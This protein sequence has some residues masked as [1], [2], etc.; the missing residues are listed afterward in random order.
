MMR[1]EGEGMRTQLAGVRGW[2]AAA[3]AV[4]LAFALGAAADDK[5]L[6]AGIVT[7]VIDGD[8]FKV[9]L[10]TGP[11]TVRLGHIDAPEMNQS[12]GGAA[13]RA[14]RDRLL[15]QAVSLQV[16]KRESED[17]LVAVVFLDGENVNA[18]MVKQGHAWAYRGQTREA[19]YCV[20]ENAA[21]SLRRGLWDN[22]GQD[23]VAPWD[24]R[25]ARRDPLYF[26]TDYSGASAASCMKEIRQTASADE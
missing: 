8:T 15:T 11:A 3:V 10:N 22:K 16:I 24:W 26:I 23:W 1:T 2:Q 6:L 21:R 13:V 25:E 14:L 19:D 17:N 4:G 18:W 12:G 5:T 9:Q 20:W 7:A